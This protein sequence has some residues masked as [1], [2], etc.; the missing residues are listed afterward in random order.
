MKGGGKLDALLQAIGTYGFPIV[1][2]LLCMYYVKYINDKHTEEVSA[3]NRQHREEM[4]EV[5]TAINNN[6]V[7]LTKL[8]D[9][10]EVKDGNS[11]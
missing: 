8:C 11:N 7:A 3:L 5:T 2:A 4:A 10:L 6:T 9:K 1:V